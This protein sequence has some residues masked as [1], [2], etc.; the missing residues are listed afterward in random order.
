MPWLTVLGGW[1][2]RR[3]ST[4]EYLENALVKSILKGLFEIFNPGVVKNLNKL[5]QLLSLK[6][7]ISQ[8]HPC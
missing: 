7:W 4:R 6:H 1:R 2:L 3:I 8:S 5:L